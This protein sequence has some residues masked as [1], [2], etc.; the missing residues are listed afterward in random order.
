MKNQ[1]KDILHFALLAFVLFQ[2]VRLSASFSQFYIE[3]N[4]SLSQIR[5]NA[6]NSSLLSS[7]LDAVKDNV[8]KLTKSMSLLTD[9]VDFLTKTLPDK[10]DASRAST[11]QALKQSFGY[12]VNDGRESFSSAWE[13]ANLKADIK[14]LH[15][16]SESIQRSLIQ[17]SYTADKTKSDMGEMKSDMSAIKTETSGL[18]LQ[19]QMR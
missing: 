19:I 14:K 7:D 11:L 6:F 18:K 10:I 3:T 8:E 16:E 4:K 9:H 12:E 2:L 15:E 1:I 5:S 17:L 13:G